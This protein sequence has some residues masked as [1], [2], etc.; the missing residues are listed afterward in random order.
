V[1]CRHV[2]HD[3]PW[4]GALQESILSF[5]QQTLRVFPELNL[6]RPLQGDLAVT[7]QCTCCH[8]LEVQDRKKIPT[9]IQS[10]I[11]R[12]ITLSHRYSCT[13]THTHARTH[14]HT[15]TRTHTRTQARTH[16]R[17]RTRAHAHTHTR[18]HTRT[19]ARTRT[20]A[21]THTHAHTR[22]HARTHTRGHAHTHTRARAHACTH[23]LTRT[24]ART[25]T[26]THART[27]SRTRTRACTHAHTHA[28][29]RAL[30]HA[31]AHTWETAHAFPLPF[32]AAVCV[33]RSPSHHSH[34]SHLLTGANCVCPPDSPFNDKTVVW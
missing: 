23:A 2:T 12:F 15:R 13:H 11:N 19:H 7:K 31:H 1:L 18:A 10:P 4:P 3:L 30:T 21:L 25:H 16:A 29:T 20:H 26:R 8:D 24:H 6:G 9:H 14:R 32:K 5:I 17:T 33:H 27:H 22:T 34:L 28:Y